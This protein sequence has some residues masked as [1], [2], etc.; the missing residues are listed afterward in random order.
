MHSEE[1]RKIRYLLLVSYLLVVEWLASS[2]TLRPM[3]VRICC[4]GSERVRM[5]FD[6]TN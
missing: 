2:I 3:H 4:H 6:T 5:N 1:Q